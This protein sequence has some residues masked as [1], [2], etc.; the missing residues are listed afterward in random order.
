MRRAWQ[1]LAAPTA[2]TWRTGLRRIRTLQ[3][4]REPCK[5]VRQGFDVRDE[6]L[7]FEE[8]DM[9][10]TPWS[11]PESYKKWAPAT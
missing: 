2:A 4:Y 5:R 11:N 7:W 3:S 9:Q 10:G 6:E 8:H 1:Q